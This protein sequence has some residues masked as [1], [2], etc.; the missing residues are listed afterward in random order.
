[1]SQNFSP[2]AE[3]GAAVA[4]RAKGAVRGASRVEQAAAGE[5]NVQ[6]KLE[7]VR[8]TLGITGMVDMV[9]MWGS[10][11]LL[12]LTTPFKLP[13]FKSGLGFL[14]AVSQAAHHGT[15]EMAVFGT[16]AKHWGQYPA[17]V[18]RA[19]AANAEK[20]GMT[21]WANSAAEK[22]ASLATKG[23]NFQ[24]QVSRFFSPVTKA[25]SGVGERIIESGVTKH[26]PGFLK[27]AT[28]SLGGISLIGGIFTVAA[29]IGV[30]SS[31]VSSRASKKES[32]ALL[33][34]FASDLAG[35]THTK[36]FEAVKVAQKSEGKNRAG[37]IAVDSASAVAEAALWANTGSMKMAM[38]VVPAQMLLPGLIDEKQALA[39]YQALKMHAAGK[40]NLTEEQQQK[41]L[42][43]LIAFRPEVAANKGIYN[44]L[45]QNIA[46]EI[47]T[48]KM[49]P[50]AAIRLI[51]DDQKFGALANEMNTKMKAAEATKTAEVKP[52]AATEKQVAIHTPAANDAHVSKAEA[53]YHAAEKP[54]MVAHAQGASHHG[55]VHA[56][57]A[58]AVG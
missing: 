17:N 31:V 38:A 19:F 16:Q 23:A 53:A 6:G 39:P 34:E 57:H 20:E 5:R 40:V 10:A 43:T 55:Q 9:A 44:H 26:V 54:K 33:D 27:T 29:S 41:A 35:N 12:W 4:A 15:E 30:L 47:V 42:T 58:K 50:V 11:A 51:N 45:A 2:T 13:K 3:A 25:L 21:Q 37:K 22:S 48:R 7:G 56:S 52:V 28:R 18:M 8:S 32:A 49:E 46:K 24:G 14:K 36:F 1:M